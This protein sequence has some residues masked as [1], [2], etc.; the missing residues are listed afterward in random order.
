MSEWQQIWARDGAQQ[1]WSVPDRQVVELAERWKNAGSIRRVV[2]IGCGI[3]RH[4]RHMAQQGFDVYG[5]DHSETAIKSCRRWLQSE[6]LSGELWCGEMEE[7]PYPDATFD[8]CIAF[9][10]IYHGTAERLDGMIRLLHSKLRVGGECLV[11]LPSHENRMYGRGECLAPDTYVSPG[12]Y[13]NLFAHDGES[14]V[15]HHFC[16][17]KQVQSLFRGFHIQ[18]LKHEELQ[19]ATDR[20]K[21]EAVWISI[22]KAFFW[23]VV[24]IRKDFHVQ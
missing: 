14:G 12:M 23:R 11:T 6:N 8:A 4:V 16:S 17:R 24:A 10:S 19:L 22:P 7:I 3:G 9:N 5:S 1:M 18:S 15:P 2:D 13:G 20:G 21:T